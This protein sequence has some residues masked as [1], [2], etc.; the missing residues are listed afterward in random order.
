[1]K[2][3]RANAQVAQESTEKL[4][5]VSPFVQKER[6]PTIEVIVKVSREDASRRQILIV[7]TYVSPRLD[8]HGMQ[9]GG[10]DILV[11]MDGTSHRIDEEIDISKKVRIHTVNGRNG[12][13]PDEFLGVQI[14]GF[15]ET[16]G[17]DFAVNQD[18]LPFP[19]GIT[20][21][22]LI[23]TIHEK[24]NIVVDERQQRLLSALAKSD[25]GKARL[26]IRKYFH[27]LPPA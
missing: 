22:G 27:P 11:M 1:M 26:D 6:A 21:L 19:E 8:D 24:E 15:L 16:I 12:T 23:N 2:A 17:K 20:I 4:R 18:P 14:I 9:H 7:G 25:I 13:M 10:D 3:T 5:P